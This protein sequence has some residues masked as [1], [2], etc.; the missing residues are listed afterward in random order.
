MAGKFLAGGR[1]VRYP[2]AAA[3]LMPLILKAFGTVILVAGVPA[4]A[5]HVLLSA[6]CLVVGTLIS[7]FDREP[8]SRRPCHLRRCAARRLS[9][10]RYQ[11][12]FTTGNLLAFIV[13]ATV[14]L[15]IAAI[16]ASS[17]SG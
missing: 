11:T 12:M 8:D 2:L 1:C 13:F 7:A 3:V 5:G 15:L 10:E 14:V 6:A 17:A 9:D 16:R 4:P